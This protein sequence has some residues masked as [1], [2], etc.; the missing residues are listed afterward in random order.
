MWYEAAEL[1]WA[2]IVGYFKLPQPDKK[3]SVFFTLNT[4]TNSTLIPES[5]VFP[6]VICPGFILPGC[7]Q[8]QSRG[9]NVLAE[10]YTILDLFL[11]ACARA[12]LKPACLELCFA[13]C[14]GIQ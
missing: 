13:F 12:Y 8:F 7:S 6:S 14:K 1:I 4:L 2:S 3:V 10:R 5:I 9:A 11:H